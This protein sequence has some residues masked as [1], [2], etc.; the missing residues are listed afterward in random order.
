MS[1]LQTSTGTQV[2]TC[3]LST[4]GFMSLPYFEGT[5]IPFLHQG[6]GSFKFGPTSRLLY[7]PQPGVGHRQRVCIVTC[8]SS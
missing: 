1:A 4:V 7:Q 2:V 8:V 6:Q 3:T 5:G